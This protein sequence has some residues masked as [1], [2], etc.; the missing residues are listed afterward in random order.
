MEL[1]E[2]IRALRRAR[3]MTQEQVA[4][5][6][7][8]TATAVN[9]WENAASCPDIALLAPL[10]R[11]LDTDLND[12][13]SF[14]GELTDQEIADMTGE[15]YELAGREGYDAA[16]RWGMDRL[17][18]WP[19]SEKLA[20]NLGLTLGGALFTLVVERPEP[21]Q[22]KLEEIYRKL[23]ESADRDIR[24]QALHMVIGR[25]M[26]RGEL[27]EA[28]RL[29]DRL[30][31]RW[32]EKKGFQAGL[33][34]RRGEL[35]KAAEIYET[36]ALH[37]ATDLYTA[38]VSL[39]ELAIQEG[40][41]EDSERLAVLIRET[42]ERYHLIPGTAPVGALMEGTARRD[43]DMVLAAARELLEG[44]EQTWDGGFLYPHLTPDGAK[45][46][47]A[48]LAAGMA[49]ALLTDPDME[50]L[51]DDPE[52]RALVER[53]SPPGGGESETS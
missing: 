2:K 8:V 28:E 18:Q 43:R 17:R 13:L 26:K 45:S 19:G 16:F 24:D 47:G 25:C 10:A 32:P 23:A 21:Y 41:G 51:R 31:D 11:L 27:E 7:G 12:L 53:F 42:V 36:Q 34:R 50:F 49:A 9:K 52:L 3:G 48:P 15:A 6:L 30:S 14:R 33:A 38:L 40:R 35:D 22:E 1:S 44:L 5:A 39:Q 46:V 37:A 20:L 29:L 4:Q